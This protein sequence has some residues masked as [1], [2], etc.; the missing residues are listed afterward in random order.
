MPQ[1][2]AKLWLD[3]GQ[4]HELQP[5]IIRLGNFGFNR[6]YNG[7]LI[8]LINPSYR[9]LDWLW[10]KVQLT[11]DGYLCLPLYI[12]R[13]R[14]VTNHTS[15]TNY[16][17]LRLDLCSPLQHLK[18]YISWQSW[19]KK[20][21]F[22][23]I[24]ML[25]KQHIQ[26]PIVI[27]WNCHPPQKI[28]CPLQA[29]ESVWSL[30]NRICRN[31]HL[32]YLLVP[33]NEFIYCV[34]CDNLNFS[35]TDSLFK[36]YGKQQ[37]MPDEYNFVSS[38]AN[39]LAPQLAA[40]V[41]P[42]I[43]NNNKN[44]TAAIAIHGT[45]PD[46]KNMNGPCAYDINCDYVHDLQQAACNLADLNLSLGH[47]TKLITKQP[48]FMPGDYIKLNAER[49][50]IIN[51]EIKADRLH[52]SCATFAAKEMACS[53]QLDLMPHTIKFV[54]T[55]KPK[56]NTKYL[57]PRIAYV[58]NAIN[59]QTN[60]YA[61]QYATD[62]INQTKNYQQARACAL[63]A[64]RN[65]NESGLG[66]YLQPGT[67]VI[68]TYI[69]ND[70]EQ[71]VIIGCLD[72]NNT[73][74]K[75]A[76]KIPAVIQADTGVGLSMS[77]D[78]SKL[79]CKQASIKLDC[80]GITQRADVIKFITQNCWQAQ[81]RNHYIRSGNIKIETKDFAS[82][83]G[84]KTIM[85]SDKLS[86]CG[87]RFAVNAKQQITLNINDWKL[88]ANNISA[89][90]KRQ[91]NLGNSSSNIR[92]CCNKLTINADASCN[93]GSAADSINFSRCA[94]TCANVQFVAPIINVTGVS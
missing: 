39:M 55:T 50:R 18:N 22:E 64:E 72:L 16:L 51:I 44:L 88:N 78:S 54:A 19:P 91:I 80:T 48:G 25:L 33:R 31:L 6:S 53:Y 41:H 20:P 13:S 32:N 4:Q 86:S 90:A 92:L 94:I 68:V 8:C 34:F 89:F 58:L 11:L 75:T 27:K 85:R 1:V 28:I 9:G 61:V 73:T 40:N 60:L 93:I 67:A 21:A 56:P 62:H 42:C 45:Y 36:N 52:K 82:F 49:L 63:D 2:E 12:Y 37:K 7:Y 38:S 14:L 30:F 69:N 5:D 65:L 77:A 57:A 29:D 87:K 10:R 43:A 74:P 81:C 76:T 46:Q 47:K 24:E 71:A 79:S 26:P 84:N 35:A 59:I 66:L 70:P 15:C 23:I 3:N 83:A 17:R